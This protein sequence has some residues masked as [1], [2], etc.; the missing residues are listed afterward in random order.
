MMRVRRPLANDTGLAPDD[1]LAY[2]YVHAMKPASRGSV[3]IGSSDPRVLPIVDHGFLTD[4]AGRDAATLADGIRL[5]RR[6]ASAEAL[7]GLLDGEVAPGQTAG[8]DEIAEYMKRSVGGYWHPVGTCKMGPASEVDTV[9]DATGRLLGSDNVY[10][11]D[12]SI[13]PTIPRAN[14]PSARARRCRA[15]LGIAPRALNPAVLDKVL[16]NA[17]WLRLSPS[18]APHSETAERPSTRHRR[19]DDAGRRS[20]HRCHLRVSPVWVTHE[21]AV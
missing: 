16:T 3:R 1:P 12:A 20:P 14:T 17:A 6:V 15:D 7:R 4:E 2:L 10:V 13:M 18:G 21:R 9:V 19:P 5:A 8:D 11:A